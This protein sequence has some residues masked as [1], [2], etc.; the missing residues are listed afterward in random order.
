MTG[1]VNFPSATPNIGLPLLIAGQ[2]QKEFFVN[3]ALGVLDALAPQAVV[4]SASAPPASPAESDCYRVTAPATQEW[5]GC[6]DHI[7]VR[8]GGSW[9]LV[10]PQ[11][12]M[13]LFDREANHSLF[14]DSGW[15]I[16]TV[17]T[18]AAG[19]TVVDAE[20]RAALLQLTDA[21][22]DLG[23]FGPTAP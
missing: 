18:V 11:N 15:R 5:A 16:G 2:S 6:V 7:A 13:R 4:A 23:L 9:H 3:Q 17:P 12:G 19:G 10:P 21:L 8:L 20:A 1:P 14:F 22:R